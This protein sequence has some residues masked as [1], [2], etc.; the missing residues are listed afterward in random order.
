[1]QLLERNGVVVLDAAAAD[2]DAVAVEEDDREVGL[3]QPVLV[4]G[5]A[6][7][8]HR[9]RH[10][11][12]EPAEAERGHLG[13]RL[14]QEPAAPAGNVEA[15]HELGEA[16]EQLAAPD[17]ALEQAEVEPRVDVESAAL[18]A[19]PPAATRTFTRMTLAQRVSPLRL[20]ANPSDR[21]ERARIG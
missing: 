17:R 12:H 8:R 21:S 9:Q 7:R 19:L 16:L 20:A 4:R 5:L 18:D 15:V 1:G 11:Q 2:L 14:D 3:L 13:D 6:E 10:R